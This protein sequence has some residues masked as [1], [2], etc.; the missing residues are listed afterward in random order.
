MH[1]MSLYLSSDQKLNAMQ[2]VICFM[3]VKDCK[4][5]GLSQN[6]CMCAEES[7]KSKGA[8]RGCMGGSSE[9]GTTNSGYRILHILWFGMHPS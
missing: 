9:S 3:Q 7:S 1:T 8:K 4:L 6:Y 5:V 2:N